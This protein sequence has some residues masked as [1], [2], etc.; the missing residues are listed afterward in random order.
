MKLDLLFSR[1]EGA[2]AFLATLLRDELD[3]RCA[4][5]EMLAEGHPEVAASLK[6]KKWE[7]GIEVD[8]INV[9]LS[10]DDGTWEILIENKIQAGS[11]RPK[12]LLRYYERQ[13]KDHPGPC[14]AMVYLSP[15]EM[16]TDEVELVKKANC[17]AERGCR[18]LAIQIS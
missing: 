15:A 2:S 16:G 17:F 12:Q 1:E 5:F 10:A 18:D 7:V 13:I 11:K 9:H 8:Q 4:F 3:F 14:V 6:A